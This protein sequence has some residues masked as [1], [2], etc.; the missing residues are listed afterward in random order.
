MVELCLKDA[1]K[2]Q[3]RL[4]DENRAEQQYG[5]FFKCEPVGVY[6]FICLYEMDTTSETTDPRWSLNTIQTKI[7][8]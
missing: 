4:V 8:P 5:S 1:I 7:T 6:T 2:D 3:I